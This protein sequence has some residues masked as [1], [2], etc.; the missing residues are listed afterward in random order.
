MFDLNYT[1]ELEVHGGMLGLVDLVNSSRQLLPTIP[2]TNGWSFDWYPQSRSLASEF[3]LVCGKD[4][5]TTLVSSGQ[6]GIKILKVSFVWN[7][8]RNYFY[9]RP[10]YYRHLEVSLEFLS[11]AT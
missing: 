11:E 3:G 7:I 5:L 2:C 8:G 6:Q 1:E 4:F 10:S 9:S